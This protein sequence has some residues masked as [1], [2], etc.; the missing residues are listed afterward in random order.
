MTHETETRHGASLAV[1]TGL[2]TRD[3]A[4]IYDL[5]PLAS[6]LWAIAGPDGLDPKTVNI[7]DLPAGCRWIENAEWA[8]AVQNAEARRRLFR[9]RHYRYDGSL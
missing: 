7:D 4:R 1:T 9:A 3:G 6:T 2:V 5:D 8:I